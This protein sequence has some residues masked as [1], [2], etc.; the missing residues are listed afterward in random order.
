MSILLNQVLVVGV[1]LVLVVQV[2]ALV[3]EFFLSSQNL[4]CLSE[5]QLQYSKEMFTI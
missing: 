1:Q 4:S 2:L 5:N 3:Q